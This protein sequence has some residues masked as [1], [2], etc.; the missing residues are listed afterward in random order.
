MYQKFSIYDK[1]V[2]D[3]KI[4]NFLLRFI[5]FTAPFE[6][7][8]EV[9]KNVN[10]LYIV[11]SGNAKVY[12]SNSFSGGKEIEEGELRGCDIKDFDIVEIKDGDVLL[13]PAN[14]AHKLIV[15]DGV[16]MQFILK[17]PKQ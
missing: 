8:T 10:D 14:T 12:I 1:S 17:I 13:I 6:G 4:Y 16:F 15:E 11:Y 9:H 7:E 2:S 5:N 3:L